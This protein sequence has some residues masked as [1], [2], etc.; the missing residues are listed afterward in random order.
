M[1]DD[2]DHDDDD[3]SNWESSDDNHLPV[4]VIWWRGRSYAIKTLDVY[5]EVHVS[6][7]AINPIPVSQHTCRPWESTALPFRGGGEA[8]CNRNS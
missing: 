4:T 2:D 6:L 8:L 5:K 7:F 3:D 1:D